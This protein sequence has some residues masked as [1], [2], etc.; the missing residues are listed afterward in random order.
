VRFSSPPGS[1][2][3][4]PQVARR[5]INPLAMVGIDPVLRGCVHR[6]QS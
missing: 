5:W 3:L 1:A 2:R 4:A 6:G